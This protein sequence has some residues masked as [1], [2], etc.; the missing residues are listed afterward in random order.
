MKWPNT[1][2]WCHTS[3]VRKSFL[4]ANRHVIHY[5]GNIRKR[6]TA[7]EVS[8]RLD[9]EFAAAGLEK[10]ASWSLMAEVSRGKHC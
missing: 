5:G 6:H 9:R 3:V 2:G 8:A 1:C 7:P 10:P 4:E